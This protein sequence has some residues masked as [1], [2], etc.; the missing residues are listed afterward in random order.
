MPTRIAFVG[1]LWNSSRSINSTSVPIQGPT[2]TRLDR[3]S[4][5]RDDASHSLR[6]EHTQQRRMR[7]AFAFYSLN[8]AYLP[9]MGRDMGKQ[10]IPP[11]SRT[12]SANR[13]TDGPYI[14]PTGSY[15]AGSQEVRIFPSAD[16]TTDVWADVCALPNVLRTECV[17]NCV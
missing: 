7:T 13:A 10:V 14:S 17:C 12:R 9:D 8:V 3:Q 15:G 5:G 2:K 6:F 11:T 16:H 1:K 4:G